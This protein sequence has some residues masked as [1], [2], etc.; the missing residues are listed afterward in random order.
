MGFYENLNI[1]E[2]FYN[3]LIYQQNEDAALIP[4]NICL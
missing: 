1:G 4:K 3:F 2:N